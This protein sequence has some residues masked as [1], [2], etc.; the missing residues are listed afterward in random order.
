MTSMEEINGWLQNEKHFV[1]CYAKEALPP[2]PSSFPKSM[3]IK[4]DNH[5]VGIVLQRKQCFYFDSYG[6]KIIDQEL[7]NYLSPH[8]VFVIFSSNVIQD[9]SSKNCG[10]FCALFVHLVFN[11]KKYKQFINLFNLHFK[12]LNDVVVDALFKKYT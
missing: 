4:C 5:F 7:I 2:F 12:L 6:E 11:K 8:Y 1:G 3:I 10:K 9:E